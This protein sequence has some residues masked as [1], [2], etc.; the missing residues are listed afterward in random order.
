MP[1]GVD[2]TGVHRS[3][4]R[5][6][7]R[8]ML[9]AHSRAGKPPSLSKRTSQ[10]SGS[11]SRTTKNAALSSR[12]TSFPSTSGGLAERLCSTL[13]PNLNLV[14]LDDDFVTAQVDVGVGD[15]PTGWDVV[16]KAVPGAGH[17]LAVVYPLELPVALGVGDE[18][19]QGRLALAQ[20]PRLVGTDV[21][22]PVE[23]AV[24]VE[25]PD[26]APTDVHDLVG[27][28]REIGDFAY[29][30]LLAPL[31]LLLRHRSP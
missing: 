14:V 9:S 13:E 3:S 29:H 22:Q 21:G 12:T 24:Y 31:V 6:K 7:A 4:R 2:G 10:S 18:G 19:A 23:L 16:L 27:A 28:L 20:G 11:S 30:V 5:L 15:A 1:G 25:Y 8:T 26:L 17:D